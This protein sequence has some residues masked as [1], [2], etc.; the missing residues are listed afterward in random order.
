MTKPIDLIE[1]RRQIK[2][3]VFKVYL[4]RKKVYIEGAENGA[5]DYPGTFKEQG[6]AH[7]H[8]HYSYDSHKSLLDRKVEGKHKE[9]G[10]E[11]I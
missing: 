7:G 9:K 10:Q 1:L 11:G 2:E 8:L 5:E 4:Y 3:G 6:P